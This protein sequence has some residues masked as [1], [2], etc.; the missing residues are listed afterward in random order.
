MQR[1]DEQ[2][3]E[4]VRKFIEDYQR[5]NGMS[6]PYRVIMKA[7]R[8]NNLAAVFRHVKALEARGVI[9]KTNMGKIDLPFQLNTGRTVIAPL[10]GTV[11]CGEPQVALEEIEGSFALPADFFGGNDKIMLRAKGDS[12]KNAGICHGDMLIIESRPTAENGE[13]VIAMIDDFDQSE[14]TTKRYF[15]EKN[16]KIRLHPE[17][18]TMEDMY[19]DCDQVRICGVVV[20][21]MRSYYK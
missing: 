8:F 19:Y 5:N 14:A 13:I 2:K 11:P 6:P 16:G 12:M 9:Q 15:K 4:D 7:M 3:I 20:G 21:V 1:L 10:V 17:N 18:E